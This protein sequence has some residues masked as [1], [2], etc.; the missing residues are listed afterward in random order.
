MTNRTI[1]EIYDAIITEKNNQAEL[2]G[3]QP[4]IDDAQ[5]LLNDLNTN[6]KVANWRLFY[7]VMAFAIW[8]HETIVFTKK[9]EIATLLANKEYG[10]T[11]WYQDKAYEFQYGDEIQWID[12]RMQYATVDTTKRII[13]RAAASENDSGYVILKVAKEVS[14]EITQ[15]STEELLAITTYFKRKIKPAGIKLTIV[16]LAAAL[17]KFV[18][19][20]YYDP[21]VLTATGELIDTAGTFPVEDAINNHLESLNNNDF[22]G[23]L[24]LSRLTDD[25]QAARGVADVQLNEAWA[26]YGNISYIAIDMKY[27][28]VAGYIKIDP[29]VPFSEQITYIANQ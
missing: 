27:S 4:E 20:I 28:T 1:K 29:E 6:S 7:W 13:T 8:V 5:T 15:L 25:I 22:N 10:T 2:S 26:K 11:P 24:Y 14:G 16:S 18:L 12:G 3:L 19:D 23:T 9:T 17:C 21:M